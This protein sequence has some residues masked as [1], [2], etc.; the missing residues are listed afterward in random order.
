MRSHFRVT[1]AET[2]VH[3]ATNGEKYVWGRATDGTKYEGILTSFVFWFSPDEPVHV[4]DIISGHFADPSNPLTIQD[5]F[6]EQR[7]VDPS[8]IISEPEPIELPEQPAFV[9]PAAPYGDD[10][11]YTVSNNQ[12]LAPADIV[13]LARTVINLEARIKA[14]EQGGKN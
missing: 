13:Q 6:V 2:E 3:T 1:S 10:W 14:I 8:T 9:E 12:F 5:I 7:Y 11:R 4:N